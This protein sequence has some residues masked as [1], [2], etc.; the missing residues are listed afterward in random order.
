MFSKFTKASTA[1]TSKSSKEH[2]TTKPYKLYPKTPDCQFG[3]IRV[4]CFHT[5]YSNNTVFPV[6]IFFD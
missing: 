5:H 6:P 1:L 4:H 2:F 3:S